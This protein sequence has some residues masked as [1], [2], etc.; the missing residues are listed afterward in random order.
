MEEPPRAGLSRS[1]F[2]GARFSH[3]RADAACGLLA[4]AR[5]GRGGEAS[6]N[7]ERRPAA[8]QRRSASGATDS[9]AAAGRERSRFPLSPRGG[10]QRLMFRK[11]RRIIVDAIHLA[12]AAVA[13][14]E[15]PAGSRFLA[16]Q[17]R[18]VRIEDLLGRAP[19][20]LET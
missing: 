4:A 1:R 6:R 7:L 20:E 2:S 5:P 15:A 14:V 8:A 12:L 19:V 18:D 13:A 3:P 9:L 17:I 10:D 16:R 11:I